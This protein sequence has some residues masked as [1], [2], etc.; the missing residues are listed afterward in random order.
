MKE[1]SA[2]NSIIADF[3]LNGTFSVT[4]GRT[5]IC[6]LMVDFIAQFVFTAF[7]FL[8]LIVITWTSLF[9]SVMVLDF[10]V[11]PQYFTDFYLYVREFNTPSALFWIT[12]LMGGLMTTPIVII[13]L[14]ITFIKKHRSDSES[15]IGNWWKSKRQRM[16]FDIKVVP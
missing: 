4:R 13:G 2:S 9:S 7:M 14:L 15:F 16:C 6:E 5:D 12:S 10:F 3:L 11:G 1:L 8:S